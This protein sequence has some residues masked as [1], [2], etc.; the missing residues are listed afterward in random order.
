MSNYKVALVY[1]PLCERFSYYRFGP[2]ITIMGLGYLHSYLIEHNINAEQINLDNWLHRKTDFW[3]E[4]DTYGTLTDDSII[5]QY[6]NGDEVDINFDTVYRF[7][8][9]VIDWKQYDMVAVS[10]DVAFL[11]DIYTPAFFK[12]LSKISANYNIP[13]VLGGLGFASMDILKICK[14]FDFIKYACFGRSDSINLE[15][16]M[17]IIQYENKADID[18]KQIQ[19]ICYR[20]E[21]S[22]VRANFAKEIPSPK[23]ERNYILKPYY[24]LKNNKGFRTTYS[25]FCQIDSG[26]PDNYF[27]DDLGISIIPYRFSV[28]CINKCAFCMC[29]TDGYRFTFKEPEKVVDDLDKLMQENASDCFMFFNAMVN[30]SKKYL[31]KVDNLGIW[32]GVNLISGLPQERDEDVEMTTNFIKKNISMVDMWQVTPFYLV[33]SSFLENPEK[34]GIKV[35]DGEVVED[36]G[37]GNLIMASFDEI[38]GLKWEEKKEKTVKNF[39][40]ILETIDNHAVVP[41]LSNMGLLFFLYKQFAFDK[42]R[43]KEWL[44]KNYTGYAPKIRIT[45]LEKSA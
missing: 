36:K 27:D 33:K 35:R 43:V 2:R 30:F 38:N 39:K 8:I 31:S 5:E 18:L 16:F 6:M 22:R 45:G 20:N 10:Y 37:E 25:D 42:T 23:I 32:N 29:S 12:F 44:A 14:R 19:N 26:L 11:R 4:F 41:N 9:N 21:S 1:P 40:L 7:L 3:K 24:D 17:K 28:N 34:Y 13:I 15:S